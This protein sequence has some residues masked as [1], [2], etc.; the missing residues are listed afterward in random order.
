MRIAYSLLLNDHV[1]AEEAEYSDSASF[2]LVCPACR[3]AVFK[4]VRPTGSG[5]THY[6]AHYKADPEA[7]D[8]CEL[9]VASLGA[10]E[11]EATAVE[12]RG[13]NLAVFLRHFQRALLTQHSDVYASNPQALDDVRKMLVR[14]SLTG[15]MEVFAMH[16][17]QNLQGILPEDRRHEVAIIIDSSYPEDSALA[18]S[19]RVRGTVDI[20]EHLVTVQARPSLRFLTAY[21][22][23]VVSEIA[24]DGEPNSPADTIFI[25]MKGMFEN[26]ERPKRMRRLLPELDRTYRRLRENDSPDRLELA[27]VQTLL[28]SLFTTLGNLP[29]LAML[30]T[31]RVALPAYPVPPDDK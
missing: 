10:R 30:R 23:A 16:L 3:E 22:F 29:Y 6:F 18:R 8:R 28:A 9:R 1:R 12:A 17:L 21:L 14:K 24:P 5:A 4:R 25:A 19:R 11:M 13:Q 20:L 31:E 7:T 15:G 26:A 2:G 27:I